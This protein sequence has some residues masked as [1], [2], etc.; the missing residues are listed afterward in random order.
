MFEY[1]ERD[2]NILHTNPL[3][4]PANRVNAV[5]KSFIHSWLDIEGMDT[6]DSYVDGYFCYMNIY[7]EH[8][9]IGIYLWGKFFDIC[10][11]IFIV[12][13]RMI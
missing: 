2:K 8:F 11:I 6:L 10:D 5:Q 1:A 12:S 9:E 3:D 4:V 13:V 7:F